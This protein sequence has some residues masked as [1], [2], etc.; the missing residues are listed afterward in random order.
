MHTYL[1]AATC[2]L[3]VFLASCG[4]GSSLPQPGGGGGG[5][6][7]GNN[8]GNNGGG[9]VGPVG[10]KGDN[11]FMEIV[12]PG[13]NGNSAGGIGGPSPLPVLSYP[14]NYRDQLDMYGNLSYAKAG[15]KGEPCNPPKSI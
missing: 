2:A 12:P 4:G 13:S 15:L 14:P 7:G 1:K 9:D 8:G 5:D 10:P 6:T 11:I 3:V